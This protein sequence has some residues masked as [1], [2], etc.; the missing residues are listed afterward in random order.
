MAEAIRARN[1]EWKR[2]HDPHGTFCVVVIGFRN[3]QTPAQGRERCLGTDSEGSFRSH[4]PAGLGCKF[5]HL[6][7]QTDFDFTRHPV[8]FVQQLSLQ[9]VPSAY[10]RPVGRGGGPLFPTN[11]RGKRSNF[12]SLVHPAEGNFS[13]FDASNGR[14][15]ICLHTNLLHSP[16]W[17]NQR[18]GFDFDE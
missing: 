3:V 6:E 17:E 16:T 15:V 18:V 5:P 10:D 4:L 12:F 7:Q 1:S 11:R 9:F 2:F 13:Y 8:F 14:M